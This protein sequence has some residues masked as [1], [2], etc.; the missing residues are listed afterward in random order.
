MALIACHDAA[1]AY[2]G[3]TVVGGLHFEITQGDYLCIVGENGSGKSTLLKGLLR[4]LRPS[5]GEVWTDA[6]LNMNDIGYLPQHTA[7]PKDFPA[8]VYE[9]VLSGRLNRRGLWPFYTA[10]DKQAA[11]AYL[12]DMGMYD[13]RR[14]C[15]RELSGGQQQRVLM[16][17]ALCAARKAIFLDE[18]A[19][20]LD[21]AATRELY[22]HI[23]TI[24][25]ASDMTV[26]MVSHDIP[27]A[28]AYA[29]HILHI[30]STQMF[31]GTAAEYVKS[32]AGA[33]FCALADLEICKEDRESQTG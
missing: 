31:F 27:Y 4:L 32:E 28:A 15:F 14:Q 18:P 1:F 19:A 22:R 2:D 33:R 16:A 29:K 3:A 30:G 11:K 12:Q 17:R 10:A 23:N 25:R 20:G 24:N 9:V 7:A 8:S 13:L 6:S 5:A 26:V 21:P